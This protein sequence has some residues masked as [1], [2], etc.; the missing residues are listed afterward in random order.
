M[1]QQINVANHYRLFL[2]ITLIWVLFVEISQGLTA[3]SKL[4]RLSHPESIATHRPILI[5]HR[6]GIITP[7]APEC[8]LTAI[9]L[10]AASH[11]DMI[12]LDIQKSKDGV[13]MVFHDAT[14]QKACGKKARVEDYTSKELESIR[15]LK[16]SDTIIRLETALEACRE[17][18]MGIM[19]D[20]KKGRDSEPFLKQIDQLIEKHHLKDSAI[21]ITGSE[22]ARH[23]LSHVRFTT[24]QEEMKR[25]RLDEKLDLS[26]R[27]WFGLPNQLQDGDIKRLKS[28]GALILPAINT[29]RYPAENHLQLAEE[30]IKR[31][32][33]QG[34]DGF[35]IDSIYDRFFKK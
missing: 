20:I 19:L 16:G 3:E 12:E 11:Y 24:T 32:E 26:H 17:L 25:L 33:K 22:A 15:Y 4:I 8:S 35:Q 29:F 28:A 13:P 23:H 27:F 6:G 14:L 7:N 34:V 31:L 5:A 9:R 30:D 2:G 18:G 10:A 1:L 21:S